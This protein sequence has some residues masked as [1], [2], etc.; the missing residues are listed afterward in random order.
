MLSTGHFFCSGGRIFL[1][2][3][4]LYPNISPAK[5]YTKLTS[6]IQVLYQD[7]G[8]FKSYMFYLSLHS[9]YYNNINIQF[10]SEMI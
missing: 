6:N 10:N 8:F 4:L 3:W 7:K 2:W 5:W 1:T 9:K